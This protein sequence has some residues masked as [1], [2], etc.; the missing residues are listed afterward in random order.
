MPDFK[1]F[2][3]QLDAIEQYIKSATDVLIAFFKNDASLRAAQAENE[4][5]A[6]G[7]QQGSNVN[8]TDTITLP[9][10]GV[11]RQTPFTEFI[12]GQ[13]LTSKKYSYIVVIIKST[14][15]SGSYSFQS[16]VLPDQSGRGHEIPVGGCSFTIPGT[17]NIQN[18]RMTPDAGQTLTYT[19]QGFK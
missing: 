3:P 18:F 11:Q 15:G 7:M 17:K 9:N 4:P 19:I 13:D 2:G 6:D 8:G 12:D 14:S 5:L 1:V 10:G 16:G